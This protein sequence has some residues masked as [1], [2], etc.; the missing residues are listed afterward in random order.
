MRVAVRRRSLPVYLQLTTS[1]LSREARFTPVGP[2]NL[3]TRARIVNTHPV[4]CH[5]RLLTKWLWRRDPLRGF[6]ETSFDAA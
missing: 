3:P 4:K 5:N 2:V 1:Q 6:L